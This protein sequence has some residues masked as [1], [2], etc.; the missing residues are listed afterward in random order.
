[1]HQFCF[2][3]SQDELEQE[4]KRNPFLKL[5]WNIIGTLSCFTYPRNLSQKFWSNCSWNSTSIR[6]WKDWFHREN[7]LTRKDNLYWWEVFMWKLPN[8]IR[9]VENYR[10][11]VLKQF[12]TSKVM[13]LIWSSQNTGRFW[14]TVYLLCYLDLFLQRF[15]VTD[16]TTVHN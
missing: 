1:M 2:C 9:Q 7:F 11:P 13:K 6:L 8:W 10:V 14:Q 12:K 3:S 5:K 4:D 15:I 16:E